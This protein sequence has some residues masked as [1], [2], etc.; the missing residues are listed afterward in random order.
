MRR[1]YVFGL[2][3]LIV[4][5]VFLMNQ[6][7]SPRLPH[8]ERNS[9]TRVITPTPFR[10]PSRPATSREIPDD[11]SELDDD[12]ESGSF[13]ENTEDSTSERKNA[14][15]VPARRPTRFP[16]DERTPEKEEPPVNVIADTF[17]DIQRQGLDNSGGIGG[18]VSRR[19]PGSIETPVAEATGTPAPELKRVDG[20]ARGFAM[21]Y[22]MQPQARQLVELQVATLLK[23]QIGTIYVSVL[24]DGTFSKEYD[25]VKDV[26]SRLSVDGRKVLLSLYLTNGA[27]QRSWNT[28]NIVESP[29]V[30]ISPQ[31]F[32]SSIK[33]D[34]DV[35]R[36]FERVVRES[37]E[38][39]RHN[40]SVNPANQNI[41]IVMLEDNLDASS[42]NFMRGLALQNL[43]G[44]AEF[45]RNPCG[46]ENGSDESRQGDRLEEH[47]IAK[48]DLLRAGDGYSF[49]GVGFAY[50]GEGPS[51]NLNPEE[52]HALLERSIQA[53]LRYV[54]LWRPD[55]QGIF[56]TDEKPHPR[57]RTYISPNPGQT[58]FIIQMLRMGLTEVS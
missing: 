53:N 11:E 57:D 32:R 49:D 4:S 14:R 24:V 40:V 29:F 5:Y 41:A 3:S 26:I 42:Y 44:L 51:P 36:L 27:T 34:V 15:I 45:Y 18:V 19:S 47:A 37:M 1:I 16:E 17:R 35:Q 9:L 21:L 55:W 50:P 39:F 6:E 7:T 56:N 58:D 48:F 28:T 13:A 33:F 31:Q 2:V 20:Q 52:L 10:L 22:M 12:L 38:L 54:A 23:A 25:Y 43:R 46:C 30:R 8:Q